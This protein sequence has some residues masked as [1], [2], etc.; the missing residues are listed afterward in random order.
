MGQGS[1]L[2]PKQGLGAAARL[3]PDS[4]SPGKSTVM[5]PQVR[6]QVNPEPWQPNSHSGA[7]LPVFMSS[8]QSYSCLEA[9][10]GSGL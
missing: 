10:S 1:L 3:N 6:R 5:R 8:V 7:A 9:F 2:A 4:R